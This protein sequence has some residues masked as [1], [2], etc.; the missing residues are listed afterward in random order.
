MK[1]LFNDSDRDAIIARLSKV[2][3]DTQRKWGTMNAHQMIVHLADPFRS[4]LGERQVTMLDS[5]LRFF[6]INKLVSQIMPWPKGAPTAPGFV[7][8]KQGSSPVEFEKDR[9]ELLALLNRFSQ[10]QTIKFSPNP[11][12]GNLTSKEWARLMWRHMNHHLTQF[13]L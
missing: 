1:N 10:Q 12:F 6:P 3:P 5:P 8:G 13:G 11:T 7:Q 2:N 4:A 9:H